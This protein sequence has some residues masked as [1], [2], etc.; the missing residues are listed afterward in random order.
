MNI[1]NVVILIKRLKGMIN[2]K[3][4]FL[5]LNEYGY[6]YMPRNFSKNLRMKLHV[7]KFKYPKSM[8]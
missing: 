2:F 1:V 5:E 7:S 3:L 6:G 8:L 4:K